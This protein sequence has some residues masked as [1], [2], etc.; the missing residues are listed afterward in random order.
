MHIPRGFMCIACIRLHRKCNHL[1]FETY[2]PLE[3]PDN[4]GYV[5][6][7]CEDFERHKD[8]YE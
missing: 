5:T 2:R 6:V 7:K 3:K 8:T 4:E 1:P